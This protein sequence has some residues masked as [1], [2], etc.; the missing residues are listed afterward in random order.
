M[1]VFYDYEDPEHMHMNLPKDELMYDE[2]PFIFEA[3]V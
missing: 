2:I 3:H 1:Q